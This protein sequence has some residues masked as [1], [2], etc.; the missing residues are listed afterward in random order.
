MSES[1]ERS[2]SLSSKSGALV[3]FALLPPAPKTL[4]S[5][6]PIPDNCLVRGANDGE[7][8]GV[9]DDV[10]R[11]AD[12]LLV[13]MWSESFGFYSSFSVLGR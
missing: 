12:I 4:P 9:F 11:M 1:A 2:D 5:L 13:E 3:P 10:R 7:C 6:A 8:G